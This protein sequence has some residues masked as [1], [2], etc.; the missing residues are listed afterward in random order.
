MAFFGLAL[1]LSV[2]FSLNLWLV[3]EDKRP[4]PYDY[5]GYLNASITIY[6]AIRH[7]S[8]QELVS[9]LADPYR[10]PLVPLSALPF[11]TVFGT[12]YQSAMLTNLLYMTILVICTYKLARMSH[13]AEVGLIVA[14]IIWAVPGVM[15]YARIFGLDF[16]EAALVSA[17]LYL[18]AASKGFTSR[19]TSLALGAVVGLGLLTKWSYFVFVTP[20]IV[21]E[22][23]QRRQI[24]NTRNVILAGIVAAAISSPWYIYAVS[25]G[26]IQ[27]L[28]YYAWGA[29]AKPYA[30]SGSL[31]D[32]SA[33][34][35]YPR[36]TYTHIIGP[37]FGIGLLLVFCLALPQVIRRRASS[38]S[39]LVKS[40]ALSLLVPLLVFAFLED[41]G[42]RFF[43]PALPCLLVLLV[44]TG[45][46]T[47]IRGIRIGAFLLVGVLLGGS[48]LSVVGAFQPAIGT[49][50]QIYEPWTISDTYFGYNDYSPPK[51]YDW[52]VEQVV[53]SIGT[54]DKDGYVATLTSHWVFNQDTLNYYAVR[55]GFYSLRF[56]DFRDDLV[57]PPYDDLD[58]YDFVLMK[59]DNVGESWNTN[60]VRKILERLRNPNDPF[61]LEHEM[62]RS[63]DLPDGSQL[64]LFGRGAPQALSQCTSLSSAHGNMHQSQVFAD[65]FLERSKSETLNDI[66]P[67]QCA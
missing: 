54:L 41:K 58:A 57:Y 31:F 56:R 23:I 45:S 16:P 43:L 52:K 35:Y 8:L 9:A 47:R 17:G 59:T 36:F 51:P 2:A 50:F 55:L 12:S 7:G 37:V 3:A 5:A 62:I 49:R 11:Y 53:E 61:Y 66:L 46:G 24:V 13:S 10:P 15:N 42:L 19:G 48:F 14:G 64:L 30:P 18:T 21:M 26:L 22:L 33:L 34:L 65:L 44:W 32:L 25:Q 1:I 40:L 4:P 39:R 63:F 28:A 27:R 67:H 60:N 6:D 29:A 20:I 38:N